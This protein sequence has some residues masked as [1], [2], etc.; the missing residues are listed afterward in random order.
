M[1]K[2]SSWFVIQLKTSGSGKNGSEGETW[3]RVDS[4]KYDIKT[5]KMNMAIGTT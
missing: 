1:I 5:G 4:A 3:V 2:L